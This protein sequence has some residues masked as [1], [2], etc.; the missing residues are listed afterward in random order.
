MNRYPRK[1]EHDEDESEGA[2]HL[3]HVKVICAG[4]VLSTT[5]KERS[6][7]GQ[8]EQNDHRNAKSQCV[9]KPDRINR[10]V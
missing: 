8:E 9:D 5:W 2:T 6:E 1:H 4:R 10:R 7:V 3:V